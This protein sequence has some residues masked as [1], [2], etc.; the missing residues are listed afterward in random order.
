MKAKAA[1]GRLRKREDNL[2]ELERGSSTL[3]SVENSNWQKLWTCR[4]KDV[5]VHNMQSYR[6]A[7]ASPNSR[8]C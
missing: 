6:P 7:N 5:P 2:L 3:R 1:I 4:K 8:W